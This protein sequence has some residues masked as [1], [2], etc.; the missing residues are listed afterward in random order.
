MRYRT[1]FAALLVPALMLTAATP[2]EAFLGAISDAGQRA[3]TIVNQP[4]LI[5]NQVRQMRPTTRQLTELEY[6]TGGRGDRITPSVTR[7]GSRQD[8]E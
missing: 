5:A 6:M 7:C 1:L 8:G 4:T 3:Q 2:A